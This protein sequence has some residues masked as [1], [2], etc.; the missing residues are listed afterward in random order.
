MKKKIKRNPKE[1]RARIREQA[2][3]LF[4]A[5]GYEGTSLSDIVAATG[6]NKR[7]VYHYFG[8]KKGLYRA[9]FVH[10]WTELKNWFDEAFKKRLDL[11][12]EQ[13]LDTRELLSEAIAVYID[14]MIAHQYFMRLMMWEGLE[15]GEISR[16]IWT[17]I[18]G[19][20]F[21]Q[22][23]FLIKQAQ[24]ENLLDDTLDPAHFI[25][26]LLGASSFYFAYSSSIGDMIGAD[27]L[28][29][30]AL[31]KRKQQMTHLLENI[32]LKK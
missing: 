26:S 4:A 22:M 8:D 29:A 23:E 15:G 11:A 14:F 13:P 10:E 16:S 3:L 2:T 5:Q 21:V 30:A 27:P 17:D 31:S 18:R 12:G 1:T 24:H 20:L 19:P 25:I 6:T 7:M 32:Y 9:I 28:S